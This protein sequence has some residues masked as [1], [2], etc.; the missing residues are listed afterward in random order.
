MAVFQVEGRDAP[1]I[2][3]TERLAE[4]GV[5]LLRREMPEWKTAN[6]SRAPCA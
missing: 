5:D 3:I 6:A 1:R 4:V 2:L